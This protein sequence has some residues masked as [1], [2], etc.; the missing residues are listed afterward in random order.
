MA[1]VNK[2]ISS[3]SSS[4]NAL[5]SELSLSSPS[6]TT[7]T[8]LQKAFR[9]DL[10]NMDDNHSVKYALTKISENIK[11]LAECDLFTSVVT[12]SINIPEDPTEFS[13]LHARAQTL[14][15]QLETSSVIAVQQ[16]QLEKQL[17]TTKLTAAVLRRDLAEMTEARDLLA[18]QLDQHK[19]SLSVQMRDISGVGMNS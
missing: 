11:K 15:N 12:N 14:R 8:E 17:E 16:Q 5:L 18:K 1:I 19:Y 7:I 2:M 6:P 3:S 13:P 4:L 10:L 9:N